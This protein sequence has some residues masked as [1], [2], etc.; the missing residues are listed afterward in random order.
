M[1]QGPVLTLPNSRWSLETSWNYNWSPDNGDNLP[2]KKW[3]LRRVDSMALSSAEIPPHP[4]P[5]GPP[6]KS[7]SLQT[8]SWELSPHPRAVPASFKICVFH[9]LVMLPFSEKGYLYRT[10]LTSNCFLFMWT[11]KV[12]WISQCSVWMRRRLDLGWPDLSRGKKSL[13]GKP[14]LPA[15]NQLAHRRTYQ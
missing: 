14:C 15:A 10:F 4:K 13:T 3:M 6:P 7:P 2:C 12:L 1:A 9:D 8:Q 5:H 11:N